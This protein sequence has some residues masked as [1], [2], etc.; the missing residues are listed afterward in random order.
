[1]PVGMILELTVNE[2]LQFQYILP[3][4]GS[5]N[6]LELVESILNKSKISD[7]KDINGNDVQQI[8]FNEK[9][10][11]FMKNMVHFLDST[12]QLQFTSLSLIRKILD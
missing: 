2:K 11:A 5:I 4:Q 7:V 3:I 6:D 8:E 1:M 10:T 12:K 9:E